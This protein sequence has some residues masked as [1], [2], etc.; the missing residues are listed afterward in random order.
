MGGSRELRRV[1]SCLLV[2][3]REA[4]VLSLFPYPCPQS[5]EAAGFKSAQSLHL[6]QSCLLFLILSPR[7]Q[8]WRILFVMVEAVMGFSGLPLLN[9]WGGN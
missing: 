5:W 9:P 8:R 6:G 4:L 1:S 7:A 3:P 2:N